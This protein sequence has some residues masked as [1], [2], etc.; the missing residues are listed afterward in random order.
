[1]LRL[2]VYFQSGEIECGITCTQC[3]D[4]GEVIELEENIVELLN[5]L[6]DLDN[7][8]HYDVDEVVV[9]NEKKDEVIGKLNKQL[10]RV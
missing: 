10:G 6:E 3:I 2:Q 5:I 7:A 1:M 8:G 9:L 4:I